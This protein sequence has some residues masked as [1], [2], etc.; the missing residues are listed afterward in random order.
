MNKFK[1]FTIVELLVVI[2][3][4]AIL[5]A[6]TIVAYTGISSKA[7]T[8]SLQ[9]DLTNAKKQL[10]LFYVDHS[11]YPINLSANCPIDP[12]TSIADN[13]YCL[14]PSSGNTFIY[15]S[16]SPY[17]AFSLFVT[18]TN[19]TKY[20]VT[21]DSKPEDWTT[22]VAADW[23]VGAAGTAMANKYVKKVEVGYL[24]YKTANTAV[25]S[26]QGATNLDL[27]Y[28]SNYVLVSPQTNP[29]VD[30]S[31]YPAQ[32]ACKAVAG[33]LPNT[34]EIVAI[35][36]SIATY[37]NNFVMGDQYWSST[38]V[39]SSNAYGFSFSSGEVYSAPKNF[40]RYVRC[41]SG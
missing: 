18:N 40:N 9:S 23:Y 13:R 22:W 17:S 20:R 35:Y 37:G 29:S 12:I 39:S 3:V 4:I 31:A 24:Q 36:G 8:S 34:Q 10:A 21:N 28:P 5:A 7:V 14:K 41:V 6:I 15:S 2:V 26:P 19:S 38:E 16:P 27:N 33:R 30:F 25:V 1:G 11:A 32:N